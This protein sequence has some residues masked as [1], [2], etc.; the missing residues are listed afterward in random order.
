MPTMKRIHKMKNSHCGILLNR[1]LMSGPR[2]KL[3]SHI[4]YAALS[5]TVGVALGAPVYITPVSRLS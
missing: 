3:V 5:L 1:P 2:K 4:A